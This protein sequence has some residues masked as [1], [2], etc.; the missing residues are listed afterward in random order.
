M[1]SQ[2]PDGH[3]IHYGELMESEAIYKVHISHASCILLGSA[4]SMSHCVVKEMKDGKFL[5]QW[6]KCENEIISIS[7][8][9]DKEKII[10]SY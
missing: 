10:N 8:A 6:N 3:S 9:Q 1:T 4:M 2:T 7:Q 5:A